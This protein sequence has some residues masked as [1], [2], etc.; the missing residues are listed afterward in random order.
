MSML[1]TLTALVDVDQVPRD[2]WLRDQKRVFEQA[3]EECALAVLAEPNWTVEQAYD[4]CL[5]H[6]R[7]VADAAVFEYLSPMVLR[8]RRKGCAD[9]P[10]A[11]DLG[12]LL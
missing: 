8:M 10:E 6:P 4:R 5:A 1:S 2:A 11:G 9:P 12:H 7:R 3:T